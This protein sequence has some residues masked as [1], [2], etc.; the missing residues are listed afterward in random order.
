MRIVNEDWGWVKGRQGNGAKPTRGVA[1]PSS[2]PESAKLAMIGGQVS[3]R[4]AVK[5]VPTTR[6]IPQGDFCGIALEH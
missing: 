6:R 2:V 5:T 3:R 1:Q 4:V